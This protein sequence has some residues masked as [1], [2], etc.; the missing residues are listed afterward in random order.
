MGWTVKRKVVAVVGAFVVLLSSALGAPT[1]H[2]KDGAANQYKRL[3]AEGL[4]EYRRE[5]YV[6]A[7]ALFER[8]HEMSPN[9]RTLRGIGFAAFHQKDYVRALTALSAALEDRRKPLTPKQR[10][11]VR[12]M[13]RQAG[14]FVGRYE[15][16]VVPAAASVQID[17]RNPVVHEGKIVL[18]PGQ[19]ELVVRAAGHATATRRLDVE[20]RDDESLVIELQSLR[21][22]A[23]AAAELAV[24]EEAQAAAA[25]QTATPPPD[26]S[27]D[28]LK[29]NR[30]Q[31]S[32]VAVAGGGALSLGASLYTFLQAR[33]KRDESG[34][35]GRVCTTERGQALNDDARL[36]GNLATAM[37]VGGGVLVAGGALLVLLPMRNR[38]ERSE[39][40]GP[41]VSWA[42]QLGVGEAGL[43]VRGSF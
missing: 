25:D 1:A 6:E 11:T 13:L 23:V 40:T 35:E 7:R 28:K 5:R 31:W 15:L 43:S 38:D 17:S 21:P 41:E 16:Q 24:P 14:E 20:P 9:A 42:P 27:D 36:L 29:F 37:S 33:S 8:A 26:G 3:V 39:E 19:H 10:K 18:N 4:Q 22:A 34:C 12:K 2:A 32:G 30:M